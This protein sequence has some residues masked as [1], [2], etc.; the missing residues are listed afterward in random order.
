MPIVNV[1]A[2]LFLISSIAV[3]LVI[4]VSIKAGPQDSKKKTARFVNLI[5][6]QIIA[7]GLLALNLTE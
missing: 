1:I 4:L 7:V 2:I 5:V 6:F 3:F